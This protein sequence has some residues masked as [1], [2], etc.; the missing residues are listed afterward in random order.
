[1]D[2][3]CLLHIP[4]SGRTQ[5]RTASSTNGS[6]PKASDILGCTKNQRPR[7]PCFLR[8]LDDVGGCLGSPH[9]AALMPEA[10]RP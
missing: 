5:P 7:T 6:T 4:R 8:Q 1:M 2:V 10:L 9:E 3:I